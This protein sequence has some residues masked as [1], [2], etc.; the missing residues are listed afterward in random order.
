[1][2]LLCVTRKYPPSV[3]GMEKFCFE[4][5]S[6]FTPEH[7]IQRKILALGRSQKHLIWFM[8]YCAIYLLFNARK[9]DVIYYGDSLLSGP[10]FL[11]K[12][13]S[14]RTKAVVDVH[15]L[16]VLFPNRIYQ[17]YLKCFYS[18]FDRYICNSKNTQQTLLTRNIRKSLVINRAIA[19][20]KFDGTA[21]DKTKLR[22]KYGIPENALILLTVGRLVR[23]KGVE[24]FVRNVMPALAE[25]EIYYF[26]VGGGEEENRIKLAISECD[27]KAR[28]KLLGRVSEEDLNDLYVNSDIFVMPNIPVEN[29]PEGFGIVAIEAS[30]AKL[31]VLASDLDGIGDAVVDG[32]NGF[33]LKSQD[34]DAYIKK[35]FEIKENPQKYAAMTDG[36]RNYTKKKYSLDTISEQYI[37]VFKTV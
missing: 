19:V 2:R 21:M 29:D 30:L 31:V 7:G 33:L 4:L 12:L 1:M 34:A 28:V 14:R 36:F 23:R 5:F 17:L 16:D 25:Q 6:R 18:C 10:A 20:D 26:V 22:K 13:A 3:G 27:L 11:G 32:E 9:F 35:I 15:G 37:N 24:W 8:P